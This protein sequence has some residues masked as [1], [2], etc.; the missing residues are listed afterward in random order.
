MSKLDAILNDTQQNSKLSEILESS[1]GSNLDQILGTVERVKEANQGWERDVSKGLTSTFKTGLGGV[2]GVL[3]PIDRPRSAMVSKIEEMQTG[4]DGLTEKAWKGDYHPSWGNVMPEGWYGTGDYKATPTGDKEL[5]STK[6]RVTES[7]E[8]MDRGTSMAQKLGT[9]ILLDPVNALFIGTLTKGG[10]AGK[11]LGGLIEAHADD[12]GKVLNTKKVNVIAD[13]IKAQDPRVLEVLKSKGVPDATIQAASKATDVL[14]PTLLEKAKAGQW[15]TGRYGPLTTPRSVNVA[16]AK[17]LD[18]IN[19]ALPNTPIA[20]SF[21]NK[22]GDELWDKAAKRKEVELRSEVNE[23]MERGKGLRQEVDAL[24]PGVQKDLSQMAERLGQRVSDAEELLGRTDKMIEE[25]AEKLKKAGFPLEEISEEGY[26]YYPHIVDE[27]GV[28]EK[29]KGLIHGKR[30]KTKTPRTLP[31]DLYWITD[32]KTGKEF[33]GSPE[34]YAL[35]NGIPLEQVQKRQA[36]V[37][38][39]NKTLDRVKAGDDLP[40]VLTV[41]EL[42]NTRARHG[43][44]LVDWAYSEAKRELKEVGGVAPDRWVTP[45]L[46]VPARYIA[47]D[48][49]V[50]P[51]LDSLQRL[52]RTK[53]PPAK[54][55]MLENMWNSTYNPQKTANALQKA[56]NAHTSVWKRY[57]LFPFMEYHFRNMVGDTWNGF[58]NGWSP[59]T[60]PGDITQAAGMQLKRASGPF[61]KP[62]KIKTGVYGTLDPDEVVKAAADWGV[63]GHGQ[64][65]ADEIGGLLQPIEKAG[66]LKR[67]LWDLETPV[68][69]GSFLEDNRRLAF[70]TRRLK[71]GDTFEEAAYTV[72]K[73]LFDYN[74]LTNTERN[75]RRWAV[76]FYTWYRKNLPYQVGRLVREPGKI[77]VV[78]K[79]KGHMEAGSNVPEQDRPEWMQSRIPIHTGTNEEGE[80]KMTVL[81]SYIPTADLDLLTQSPKDVL[82]EAGSML[83]PKIKV[84]TELLTNMDLFREQEVDRLAEDDEVLAARERT[85]YLGMNMPTKVKKLTDLLPPARMLSTADRLNPFNVFGEERP[86]HEEMDTVDKI[87][88]FTTGIKR[89]PV[90]MDNQ[91]SWKIYEHNQKLRDVERAMSRAARE[92]DTESFEHY[93]RIYKDFADQLKDT[94]DRYKKYKNSKAQETL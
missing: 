39:I 26:H 42:Q 81:G 1:G 52:Q 79:T 88:K 23:I 54:A 75:I 24:P 49:K 51:V 38:E 80:E 10:K 15:A 41:S 65:S 5:D 84:A 45:D 6:Q 50:Y 43:K 70:F 22:S 55:R 13:A 33:I 31:R 8:G 14:Q 78:P 3:E 48:D 62:G 90:D 67:E 74:D 58:L 35:D 18:K 71:E 40:T 2:L 89:Y 21:I 86:Y 11:F 36:T 91:Y 19:R 63:T 73:A 37:Q 7:F 76:P 69:A 59:A 46:K 53:M 68:K 82:L 47:K 92:G 77:A 27:E 20:K 34:K 57:T 61:K 60:I 87:L 85:N 29:L 12:L 9:D 28:Y 94:S 30:P 83:D 72:N 56:W 93:K 44:D 16:T 4:E 17:G 66:R 64:Y 32:H 25:S